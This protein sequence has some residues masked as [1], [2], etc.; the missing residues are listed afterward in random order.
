MPERRVNARPKRKRDA[1]ATREEILEAATRRFATQ[2][3]ERAGVREIAADAGVTAALVNRYFGSKEEL[4]AE[5][6]RGALDMAHLLRDGRANLADHLARVVVYGGKDAPDGLLTPLLLL[7]HSAAEPGAIELFRRDLDH[8][9][10]RHLAEHIGGNDAAVRAAMVF[11]QLT[12]FAIM[13]HVLRPGA[14]AEA[15]GEE[16]VALLSRS[17]A[18]CTD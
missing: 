3:Y 16:L 12:G 10:L 6:I 2:G 18:A 13:Y 9:Q 11:A 5:V 4:F 1:A 15:C 8:T 7:L 17:I 14:L